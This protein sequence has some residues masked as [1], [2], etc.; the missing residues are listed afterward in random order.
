VAVLAGWENVVLGFDPVKTLGAFPQ[1]HHDVIG[2]AIHWNDSLSGF[3]LTG[4]DEDCSVQ[5]INIAPL[6]PLNF[7]PSHRCAERDGHGILSPLPVLILACV[8]QQRQFFVI[9]KRSSDRVRFLER[10][11]ISAK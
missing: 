10:A 1:S 11:N 8:L 9:G 7:A 2:F 3:C 5:E 4:A 6:K